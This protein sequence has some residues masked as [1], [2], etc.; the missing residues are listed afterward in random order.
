LFNIPPE[1]IEIIVHPEYL[2]H[3]MVEFQDGSIVAEIG[4]PN[5]YR[6]IQYAL[7]YPKRRET[8]IETSVDLI[9]KKLSFEPAPYN[10]FPGLRL[11]F[12]AL[13]AGGTMPAAMHGA[14]ETA[15]KQFVEGKIDFT[16]IPEIIHQT[17]ENHQVVQTTDLREIFEA[18]KWAQ[19]FAQK[20]IENKPKI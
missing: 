8:R 17:M 18:E 15:V 2:C 14:D 16:Q 7:F 5:M 13:K 20:L 19:V 9:G 3:S 1:K 6:Y 11:G 12:E 10:K 4:V